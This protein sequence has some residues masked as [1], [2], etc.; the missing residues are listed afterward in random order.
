ME[1]PNETKH[2]GGIY[3][4]IY[5]LENYGIH[6]KLNNG[7]TSIKNNDVDDFFGC[8]IDLDAFKW[9]VP[10]PNAKGLSGSRG[11]DRLDVPR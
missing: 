6:K 2:E 1:T 5:E 4:D 7:I 11:N 8:R 10:V 9:E 3:N